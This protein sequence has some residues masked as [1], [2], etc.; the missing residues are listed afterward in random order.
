MWQLQK[1]SY[2]ENRKRGYG[3]QIEEPHPVGKLQRT[4]GPIK[5]NDQIHSHVGVAE[6][7]KKM[8]E[9]FI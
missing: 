6:A 4:R 5:I 7:S 2:S 8:Q 9:E 1:Q 3:G